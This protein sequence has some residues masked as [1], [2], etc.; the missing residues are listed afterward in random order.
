MVVLVRN[1]EASPPWLT[2]Q[3]LL[4]DYRGAYTT[5]RTVGRKAIFELSMHCERLLD[6]AIAVLRPRPGE[7]EEK[8]L[9]FLEGGTKALRPELVRE[10]LVALTYLEALEAHEAQDSEMDYQVATLACQCCSHVTRSGST[11]PTGASMS[12]HCAE[13]MVKVAAHPAERR[14]PTIKDV[15]WV[16]DRQHLEQIQKEAGVNE[17][18]MSDSDGCITEGLHTNFFVALADGSL[19]PQTASKK[20]V[21]AGTVRKVVLDVASEQGL[22]V[23][24]ECPS[25]AEAKLW[26]SCFICS[27]SRLVKP[28][29]ELT[30]PEGTRRTNSTGEQWF[31]VP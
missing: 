24:F 20:R 18:I 29:C 6:T 14:S 21:L 22:V 13:A 19:S 31:L 7:V 11:R 8:A 5:A 9:V 15:Q 16:Q 4:N 25:L 12:S 10:C 30:M 2:K 23:R 17:V 27:T 3:Q 26:E 1:G 28:V